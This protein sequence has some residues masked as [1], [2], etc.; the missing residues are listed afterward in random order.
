MNAQGRPDCHRCKHY[1]VTWD[2]SFPYGCKG[3]G[4]KSK[5]FPSRSVY[6]ASGSQCL[7]FV[8]KKRLRKR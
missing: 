2:A 4:M 7:L 3:F 6:E 1:Y 8:E 5:A